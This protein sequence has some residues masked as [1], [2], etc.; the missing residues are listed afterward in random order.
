MISETS[1]ALTKG[2]EHRPGMQEYEQIKDP[3]SLCCFLDD[4]WVSRPV[5]F[6]LLWE[7]RGT[8]PMRAQECRAPDS[9]KDGVARD[10]NAKLLWGVSV[11]DLFSVAFDGSRVPGCLCVRVCTC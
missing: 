1:S 5:F 9:Q 8:R 6:P 2:Q 4:M 10:E 11:V 3:A 7:C